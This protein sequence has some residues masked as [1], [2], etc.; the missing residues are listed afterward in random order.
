MIGGGA[1]GRRGDRGEGVDRWV[2]VARGVGTIGVLCRS[3]WGS[4]RIIPVHKG[5]YYGV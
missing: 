5:N 4:A 3:E 2:M 1:V